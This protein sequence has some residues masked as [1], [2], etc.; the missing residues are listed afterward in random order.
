ML[1]SGEQSKVTR[2]IGTTSV[3]GWSTGCKQIILQLDSI[4]AIEAI[5]IESCSMY[6]TLSMTVRA[7]VQPRLWLV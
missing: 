5:M 2:N 3:L 4:E 6:N 7:I 1:E